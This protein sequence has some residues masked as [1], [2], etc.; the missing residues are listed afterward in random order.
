MGN[1][2]NQVAADREDLYRIDGLRQVGE[3][4]P[5][6]G[7]IFAIGIEFL[8][9]RQGLPSGRVRV[10]VNV[11]AEFFTFRGGLSL[12]SGLGILER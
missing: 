11:D 10:H 2:L 9:F 3:S 5:D 8:L 4:Y 6:P 1:S 12:G 7:G